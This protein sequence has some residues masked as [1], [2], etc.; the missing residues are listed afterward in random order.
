MSPRDT[1][2]P[3]VPVPVAVGLGSNLGDRG[4][5]LRRALALL[6]ERA[7]SGLRASTFLETAPVDCAPGAPAFLNAACTGFCRLSPRALLE[8]CQ[9]IEIELGRPRRHG[10][11]AD[12]S[13]DLDLLLYGDWTLAAPG[14]CVP[15]PELARRDFV[16]APL[17]EIA[18]DWRL[19]GGPTIAALLAARQ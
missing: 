7:L 8:V 14:L 13:I 3:A 18:P 2:V 5:N 11:H 16:L 12:R 1:A 19:P 6:G 10:Y 17:A 9:E 4:A 15:H